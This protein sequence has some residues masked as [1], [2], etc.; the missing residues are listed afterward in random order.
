M[1]SNEYLR[2]V[3]PFDNPYSELLEKEA[4][5]RDDIQPFVEK[6]SARLIA[7]LIRSLHAKNML[8]LG[9]GIGYSAIWFAENLRV[10]GGKLITIDSHERTSKEALLHFSRSQVAD[11]V[12][13][14]T[15][16]AADIIPKLALEEPGKY[17]IIFQDCGKYLYPLL[18]EDIYCLL[19]PGGILVSDD[20]LFPVDEYQRTSLRNHVE[21]YN[22]MLFTDS[23]YYSTLLPAGHGLAVSY[24]L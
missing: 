9:C 23:R 19:R 24:K 3:L 22:R 5:L 1:T 4:L 18:Y 13:L 10:T 12:E 17:D 7:L 16:D 2:N 8:E 6:E 15:G 11:I 14:R 21:A 20:V